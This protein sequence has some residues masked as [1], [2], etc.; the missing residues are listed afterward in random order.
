MNLLRLLLI[1]AAGWLVWRLIHQVRAQLSQRPPE[2]PAEDYQQMARCNRC[3]TF[4]PA[5]SLNSRGL[6]GRCSE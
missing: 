6:C 1:A 3:G 2:P 5:Q 4:L